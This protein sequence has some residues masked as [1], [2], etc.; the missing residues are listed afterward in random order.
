M[1]TTHFYCLL[2]IISSPQLYIHIL[3]LV[4]LNPIDRLTYDLDACH[5]INSTCGVDFETLKR[6]VRNNKLPSS[7]EKKLLILFPVFSWFHTNAMVFSRTFNSMK[8]ASRIALKFSNFKQPKWEVV[9][10]RMPFIFSK[11]RSNQ[12]TS[13]KMFSI[14]FCLIHF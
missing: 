1:E 6:L 5:K 11:N 4:F 10:Q 14:F 13:E 7:G 9:S 12:I 2:S 8:S 3:E